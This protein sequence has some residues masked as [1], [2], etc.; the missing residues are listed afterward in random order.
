MGPEA[1]VE[2]ETPLFGL[3]GEE[4]G[5]AGHVNA[6]ERALL[7]GSEGTDADCYLDSVSASGR[8]YLGEV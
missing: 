8:H 3:G 7:L 5:V 1:V 4:K 6:A 2:V